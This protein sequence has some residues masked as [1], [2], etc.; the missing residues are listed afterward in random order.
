MDGDQ[1]QPGNRCLQSFP[2][3]PLW[4]IEHVWAH[5][6]ID[7]QEVVTSSKWPEINSQPLSL[8][9]SW[10]LRVGSAQVYFMVKNRDTEQFER[11]LEFLEATFSLLPGLVAPIK[12]M[13]IMFGLKTMVIIQMLREG[14]GTVD[15]VFKIN[16]FF[17]GKLPQYQNQCNQHQMFLMKKNHLEFKNFA[18]ALAMDKDKLKDYVENQMEEQYGE[19]YAQ[20]V[21]DRLLHYLHRLETMLPGDTYVDKILMKNSPVTEEEK[22]LVEVVTSAPLTIATTLKKLLH[23]DVASCCSEMDSESSENG[24][25][26]MESSQFIKSALHGSSSRALLRSVE[27][28]RHLHETDQGVSKDSCFLLENDNGSGLR[29]CQQTEENCEVVKRI[30]EESNNEEKVETGQRGIEGAQKATSFPQFC[31]KHQRWVKSILQAC[32]NECSQE[33]QLQSNV[34][35]SPALFLSSSSGSSSGDLTPSGLI[36][37]APDQQHPPSQTSI[38]ASEQANPENNQTSGS[39]VTSG[40]EPR[41]TSDALQ[42]GLLSPVVRLI[43]IATIRGFSPHFKWQKALPTRKLTSRDDAMHRKTLKYSLLNQ[44]KALERKTPEYTTHEVQSAPVTGDVSTSTY[45]WQFTRQHSSRPLRKC[46]LACPSNI[47]AALQT[48]DRVSRSTLAQTTCPNSFPLLRQELNTSVTPTK[49]SMTSTSQSGTLN[50]TRPA[51]QIPLNTESSQQVVLQNSINS[52]PERHT[53]TTHVPVVSTSSNSNS[54]SVS[55]E[56]SR[57]QRAELRLSL[58]S[59]AMLL[60]SK[61]LQPYVSLVRLSRQECFGGSISSTG[62]VEAVVQDSNGDNSEDYRMEAGEDADSSFD[63]NVLYSS[64]SSSSDGEN[65]LDCDPD[66]KPSRKKKIF[67]LEY[68]TAR[69]MNLI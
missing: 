35:S 18:Q 56:T 45:C 38:M 53:I 34:S 62:H 37:L 60:Q 16:Q 14:R 26:E 61:L 24:K 52:H 36:P 3:L 66:Y 69:S 48:G 13:K 29:R 49:D 55:P 43:D 44:P 39:T 23:C 54:L 41:H 51:N 46:R 9:D 25:N 19:H 47:Y 64:F 7:L 42:L 31:S 6:L 10:R 50:T 33:L 65:P 67:F 5:K 68:E 11:A 63:V 2:K 30:D 1:L 28:K 21:E 58:N 22:L 20:K 40:T 32:P 17:P 59:Q 27:T 12:H 8:E 4:I 57:A 15:T